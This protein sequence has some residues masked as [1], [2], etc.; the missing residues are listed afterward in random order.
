MDSDD[1]PTASLHEPEAIGKTSCNNFDADIDPNW[2][3]ISLS[4]DDDGDFIQVGGLDTITAGE[5]L[6][7]DS[8]TSDD[9][10]HDDDEGD[11][12][13]SHMVIDTVRKEYCRKYVNADNFDLLMEDDLN[14]CEILSIPGLTP[15][16]DDDRTNSVPVL[17]AEMK[18]LAG[19][20]D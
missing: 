15:G 16:R 19:F 17:D 6:G 7:S 20:W 2:D 13:N 8:V 11:D 9:D 1:T 18:S 4:M 3:T 14:D 5:S 12:D 10:H